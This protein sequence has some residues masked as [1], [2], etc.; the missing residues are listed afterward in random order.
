MRQGTARTIDRTILLA[1][2]LCLAAKQY[3]VP[4]RRFWSEALTGR[5]YITV[6]LIVVVGVFGTL[7]PIEALSRRK[8]LAQG[9][10]IRRQILTAFGQLLDIGR[11]INPPIDISDLALHVWRKERT[12]RHPWRGQLTRVATYRLG[13]TP[14]TRAIQPTP[15]FGVVGQ[16]WRHNSE[17]NVNVEELSK[18]L[19][20]EQ[21]FNEYRKRNGEDAVMEFSWR[22]FQRFKH[23]GAVF[24]SPV[25]N[26]RSNFIGC[27]SLDA[28]H[29]YP[30]LNCP[31]TWHELNSLCVLLGQ[32]GF[33]HV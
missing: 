12:L 22:D 20:D 32:D 15:G 14:A 7:T 17:V 16:C 9:V 10:T 26:G 3:D 19:T 23:R 8:H 5:S 6:V 33:Q 29:G 1:A 21:K 25:R 31:R 24:A 13:S 18:V 30:E 27:V 28:E 4:S 11:A 2:T